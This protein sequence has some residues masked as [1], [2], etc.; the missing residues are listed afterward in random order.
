LLQALTTRSRFGRRQQNQTEGPSHLVSYVVTDN[1]N[2]VCSYRGG[3]D[4]C[5]AV[6]MI[7]NDKRILGVELLTR[8]EIL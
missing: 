1:P 8:Q 3:D 4:G 5:I 7:V 2:M 6:K